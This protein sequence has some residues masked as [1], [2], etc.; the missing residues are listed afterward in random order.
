MRARKIDPA[1]LVFG[2]GFPVAAALLT[3][4]LTALW[5]DRLPE[6]I[7]THWTSA[8]QP[9]GFSDPWSNAWLLAALVL[10]VG[11]GIGLIAAFTAVQLMMRRMMLVIGC[12]VAGMI[13]T[14]NV[15][16]MASQLDL[17]DASQARLQLWS[18]G[19]GTLIGLLVGLLGAWLLRDHRLRVRAEARPAAELPRADRLR[20]P[21]TEPVGLSTATAIAIYGLLAAVA[22]ATCLVA[23]SWWPAPL[24]AALG[25]LIGFTTRFLVVIDA[26]GVR[27][28][29]LGMTVISY[30]AAEVAGASTTT[31]N[32]FTDFGG[33]GLRVLP[34]RHYGLVTRRGP[35]FVVNFAGGDKL[36]VTT[37]RADELAA[38]INS[39]ADRRH[40]S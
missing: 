34:R 31:V 6:R 22:L 37:A 23:G 20:L 27:V 32:P 36:T 17:A 12:L 40:G 3:L 26:D 33:W 14:V 9:D 2:V 16:L 10:V 21:M 7:A 8:A 30:D 35:A 4:V 11:G 29:C 24:V 38:T 19:L 39:L 25:L 18:L 1:G 15:V 13:A 5:S 28:L